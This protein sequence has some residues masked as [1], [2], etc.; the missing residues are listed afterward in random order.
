MRRDTAIECSHEEIDAVELVERIPASLISD[1]TEDAI[2]GW[3]VFCTTLRYARDERR[4]GP[5]SFSSKGKDREDPLQPS[6]ESAGDAMEVCNDDEDSEGSE[7]KVMDGESGIDEGLCS[8]CKPGTDKFYGQGKVIGTLWTAIQTELLTYRRLTE[9]DPWISKNFDLKAVLD[10]LKNG[11]SLSIKIVEEDMMA[12][13]YRC[14]RFMEITNEAYASLNKVCT[15]YFA[16]VD[17]WSRASPV[18]IPQGHN[19]SWHF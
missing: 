19:T 5:K 6:V 9:D 17:V 13:F 12:S 1:W 11:G 10:G 3:N 15:H 18:T 7:D 16:N 8:H 2:L 4:P 14:S